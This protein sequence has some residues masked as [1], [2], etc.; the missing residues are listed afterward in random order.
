MINAAPVFTADLL[1]EYRLSVMCR[2]EDEVHIRA[3]VANALQMEPLSFQSLAS[4]DC[5]DHPHR[6]EAT[7]TCRAHPGHQ[8][9][10]E[11]VASRISMEKG[12]TSVSWSAKEAELAL[13]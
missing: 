5:D 3:V 13:E 1:R 10:I 12:V 2:E 7:A 6:I 8:G 11:Q 9:R 4:C